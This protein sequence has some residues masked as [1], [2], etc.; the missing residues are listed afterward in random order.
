MAEQSMTHWKKLENPNYLGSYA[1]LPGTDLVAQIK[2]VGQEDEIG[3][4]HV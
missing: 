2:S 1:L 4:A 3:R